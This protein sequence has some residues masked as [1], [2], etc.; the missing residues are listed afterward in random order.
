MAVPKYDN[1]FISILTFLSDGQEHVLKEIRD[2]CADSFELS[3]EDRKAVI[4]SGQNMLRSRVGWARFYLKSAGLIESPRRATYHITQL[5][6]EALERGVTLEYIQELQQRNGEAI[7]DPLQDE[8]PARETQSP[9][10]MIDYAMEQ[11]KSELVDALLT[12]VIRMDEYDFEQL[13]V[14][15]LLKMGLTNS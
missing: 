14:D 4:P 8:S 7:S 1:F 5:G 13:V 15:L 9:Q 3:E 6:R 10:E 12:E 11:L 2:Y